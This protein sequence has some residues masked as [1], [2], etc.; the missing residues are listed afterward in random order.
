MKATITIECDNAAFEDN[1]EELARI[2]HDLAERVP[3]PVQQTDAPLNLYD[4][5]GN[6]V[7][8]CRIELSEADRD[9]LAD[10]YEDS[11]FE[12]MGAAAYGDPE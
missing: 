3:A 12:D 9:A 5:N 4:L 10:N 2:L 11:R 7:G 1:P 8:E 6:W